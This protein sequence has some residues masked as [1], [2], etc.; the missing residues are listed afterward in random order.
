M[1]DLEIFN[2]LYALEPE[3]KEQEKKIS[4]M[5]TVILSK[6]NRVKSKLDT[7]L[8]TLALDEVVDK[9]V[10]RVYQYYCYWCKDNDYEPESN[11]V[12]SRKVCETFN[13]KSKQ[14]MR[15]GARYRIYVLEEL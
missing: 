1:T 3:S 7:F 15:D 13:V 14:M 11:L 5:M 8:D 4:K 6:T 10:S 2:W 12:F 9:N